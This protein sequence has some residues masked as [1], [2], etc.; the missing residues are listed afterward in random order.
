MDLLRSGSGH[1]RRREGALDVGSDHNKSSDESAKGR[2]TP[3]PSRSFHFPTRRLP[4][5]SRSFHLPRAR[6]S[7]TKRECTE[8]APEKCGYAQLQDDA[9]HDRPSA[10]R[11][12]V[13][14]ATTEVEASTGVETTS[15]EGEEPTNTSE[16]VQLFGLG[17]G[18]SDHES[19]GTRTLIHASVAA[20][21]VRNEDAAEMYGYDSVVDNQHEN[22]RHA[23]RRDLATRRR[24]VGHTSVADVLSLQAIDLECPEKY[25]YENCHELD[26]KSSLP[27]GRPVHRRPMRR[28]SIGGCS[29]QTSRGASPKPIR[30]QQRRRSTDNRQQHQHPTCLSGRTRTTCSTL[31]K[32]RA[33]LGSVSHATSATGEETDDASPPSLDLDL[34]E[35]ESASSSEDDESFGGTD[36][37]FHR[38]L[39]DSM[40]HVLEGLEALDAKLQYGYS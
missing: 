37:I 31:A 5:T 24:S 11:S 10:R 4:L 23:C 34:P 17:N 16:Y 33:S 40:V 28:A 8:A 36:L 27:H 6:P 38:S 29:Y 9:V 39:N 12:T 30:R 1:S 7:S 3:L 14:H 18:K 20:S 35:N 26:Q 22:V 21:S 2:K 25:G 15:A 19:I 13:R 32:R